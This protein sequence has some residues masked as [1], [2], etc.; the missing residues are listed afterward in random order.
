[1][2]YISYLV[3][4]P[5]LLGSEIDIIGVDGVVSLGRDSTEEGGQGDRDGDGEVHC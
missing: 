2:I 1:M 3:Q 4:T 5:C